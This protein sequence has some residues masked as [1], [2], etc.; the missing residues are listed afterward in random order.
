MFHL[1]NEIFAS[2]WKR[3]KESILFVDFYEFGDSCSG[4]GTCFISSSSKKKCDVSDAKVLWKNLGESSKV[5]GFDIDNRTILK[6][7]EGTFFETVQVPKITLGL[8]KIPIREDY[9]KYLNKN[10]K[11]R[12]SASNFNTGL[13][14]SDYD[15]TDLNP[16]IIVNYLNR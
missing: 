15:D 2:D 4:S 12:T 13:L 6:S 16:N 5:V 1:S 14:Y 11:Q 10:N 8:R 3:I 7:V 9:T